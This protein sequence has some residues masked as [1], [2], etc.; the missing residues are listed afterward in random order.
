MMMALASAGSLP[1][2]LVPDG[3]TLCPIPEKM[4]VR[5]KR[6]E[7]GL[8]SNRSHRNTQPK[9]DAAR[10]LVPEADASSL[11]P[12]Q[13]LML[14]VGLW[15]YHYRTLESDYARIAGDGDKSAR[16]KTKDN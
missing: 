11:V 12:Q 8:R 3:V 9:S 4:P 16:S 1:T 14:L 6:L 15:G 2:I 7:P 13:S 5:C 10:A